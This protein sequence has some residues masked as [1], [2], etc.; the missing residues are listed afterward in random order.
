[1]PSP[2]PRRTSRSS[3]HHRSHRA[4]TI[5]QRITVPAAPTT[6]AP[7]MASHA[8]II[9]RETLAG[10]PSWPS[11]LKLSLSAG[12]WL[13]WSHCLGI[14]MGNP[15]KYH[16]FTDLGGFGLKKN[17]KFG[18]MTLSTQK[19][20]KPAGYP[21]QSLSLSTACTGHVATQRPPVLER[22]DR[23]IL[24]YMQSHMYST[25]VLHV[26]TC[27]TSAEAFR[28]LRLCARHKKRSGMTQLQLIQKLMG[29]S[30]DDDPTKFEAAMTTY[31]D[32]IYR[33]ESISHVDIHR[34]GLLFLL[35]NVKTSHPAVHDGL[36][37]ALVDGSI[38]VELLEAR[39][40][41]HF[42]MRSAEL[43]HAYGSAP[44]S[45]LAL[46][47]YM[48]PW[49]TLCPNCK[50]TGHTT[51]FCVA[52]GGKMEGLTMF[53][54]ITRQRAT[55]ESSRQRGRLP[56][57]PTQG[58]GNSQGSSSTLRIDDDGCLWIGGVRYHP[59]SKISAAIAAVPEPS[60]DAP[61][62]GEFPD[63][64]LANSA[65]TL[66]DTDTMLI[67]SVKH[68]T[69]LLSHP[70]NFPFFLDS[71]A[72][73]HISCLHTDFSTI[74]QLSKPRKISGVGVTFLLDVSIRLGFGTG[75]LSA[76]ARAIR[77]VWPMNSSGISGVNATVGNAAVYAVGIGTVDILLPETNVQ[78]QLQN[79]LFAPDAN[80]QL[81]SIHQLNQLGYTTVFH[82]G[83]CKLTNKDEKVIADCTPGPCNLY[84]L[85]N[86]NATSG[87][88]S[89][90]QSTRSRSSRRRV[91]TMAI[92]ET[93][94]GQRHTLKEARRER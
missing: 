48:P 79:V 74:M 45:S 71:G 28:L 13:E 24:G 14:D 56:G 76:T 92:M 41:H 35:L 34:L 65:D 63:W 67:A 47:A 88:T 72:S 86:C 38:T 61:D 2:P 27:A 87:A 8:A 21:C 22:N 1:M 75:L 80:I 50:R 7:V 5:T 84:A 36:T 43:T 77:K 70:S 82:S 18:A 51:E 29:I 49:T 57:E 26:A 93:D 39:M 53:E 94:I 37:P 55:R 58:P 15:R 23:M 68:E 66:L 54:A 10:L 73:S 11:E 6:T 31:C 85:P 3:C 59:D 62:Q 91:R 64:A 40:L 90:V 52:L 12:N 19:Y 69:V 17:R 44:S 46:P 4:P 33:I 81:V 83:H 25:E 32:L 89:M 30:F 60:T 20:G 9:R 78:L 42:K 16:F